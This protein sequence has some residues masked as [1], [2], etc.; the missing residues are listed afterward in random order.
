MPVPFASLG[1][2]SESRREVAR[3]WLRLL[4]QKRRLTSLISDENENEFDPFFSLSLSPPRDCLSPLNPR[5]LTPACFLPPFL[6]RS[7]RGWLQS[8]E[9]SPFFLLPESF[10]FLS[11]PSFLFHIRP[12]LLLRPFFTGQPFPRLD[13][14]NREL[15]RRAFPFFPF[16]SLSFSSEETKS[17]QWDARREVE[18]D[19]ER[20]RETLICVLALITLRLRSARR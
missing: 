4:R 20:E 13:K 15:T 11:F 9:S 8:L 10:L 3:L 14:M 12:S 5:P 19:G 16:F 18:T 17:G 2:L 1:G 6:L 7:P